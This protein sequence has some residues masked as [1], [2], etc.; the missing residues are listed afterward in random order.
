MSVYVSLDKAL[1]Q[2]SEQGNVGPGQMLTVF[3]AVVVEQT[4]SFLIS[5][6]VSW[7]SVFC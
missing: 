4:K 3:E 2:S 1:Q 5:V 6:G 7:C